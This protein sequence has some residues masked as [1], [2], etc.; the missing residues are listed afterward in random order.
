MLEFKTMKMPGVSFRIYRAK[1]GVSKGK[2]TNI[3]QQAIAIYHRGRYP[4]ELNAKYELVGYLSKTTQSKLDQHLEAYRQLKAKT[5]TVHEVPTLAEFLPKYANILYLKNP[6]TVDR[7]TQ[8]I[9]SK[10]PHLLQYPVDQIKGKQLV[11]FVTSYKRNRTATQIQNGDSPYTVGESTLKDWVCTLRALLQEASQYTG[12]FKC[13]DSLYGESLKFKI[14][15]AS[16]RYLNVKELKFL[17]QCLKK[18]DDSKLTNLNITCCF[19]DY[20]TPLILTSLATGLRPK[21]ALALKWSDVDLEN[22][23]IKIRAT[24]GKIKET[25]WCPLAAELL[26]VFKE[27]KKHPMH[28][29]EGNWVFPSPTRPGNHLVSYKTTFTTF[30]KEYEINFVMY[31]TRHTFATLVTKIYKNIQTTQELLH[32]KDGKSTKRYARVIPTE[33]VEAVHQ[34]QT[35]LPNFSAHFNIGSSAFS[36]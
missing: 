10:F 13:C 22:N 20:L 18:R 12:L 33:R 34:L 28:S 35:E 26:I 21:Y 23:Q 16:D 9:E 36:A 27:W 4:G 11:D 19:S 8:L 5:N 15:N 25:Q 2:I 7:K 3:Q 29:Q 31:D 17:M 24:K 30:R 14:D 6:E 1:L 32:H